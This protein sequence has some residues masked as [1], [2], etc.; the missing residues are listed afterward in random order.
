MP[1]LPLE[2]FKTSGNVTSDEQGSYPDGLSVSMSNIYM[3]IF[4]VL[5]F[6]IS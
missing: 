2:T 1:Y 5:I 4:T 3:Y 6:F